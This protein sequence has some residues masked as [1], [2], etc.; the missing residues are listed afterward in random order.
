VQSDR[1]VSTFQKNIIVSVFG[2]YFCLGDLDKIFRVTFYPEVAGSMFLR[3]VGTHL[4]RCTI[5]YSLIGVY[6]NIH[7][8][9]CLLLI[10]LIRATLFTFT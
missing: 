7:F 2:I 5:F 6:Q 8:D 10:T 9:I 1:N 3:N 4:C